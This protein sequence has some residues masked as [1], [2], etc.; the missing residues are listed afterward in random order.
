MENGE[1]KNLQGRSR[2]DRREVDRKKYPDQSSS[3]RFFWR[4]FELQKQLKEQ[5]AS[6]GGANRMLSWVAPPAPDQRLG[7]MGDRPLAIITNRQY[8]R[9]RTGH[10]GQVY[11]AYLHRYPR[12]TLLIVGSGPTWKED[13]EKISPERRGAFRMAIG[14]AAGFLKVNFV[15]TDHYE[16]HDTLKRLQKEFGDDFKNHCT[17]T[18]KP[19]AYPAVDHWWNWRRGEATSV[20]TGIR[21]GL[22]LHFRE[23]ILCGCPMEHAKILHPDQIEKDGP[24]WPPPRFV[25]G[26]FIDSSQKVLTD[27]RRFF[28]I[29]SPPWKGI[30]FSMSGWTKKILGEPRW[31]G[32]M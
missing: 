22:A 4:D 12:Q 3:E 18:N 16:V 9:F 8:I 17:L 19:W 6:S 20:Q 2:L 31:T 11:P 27:A 26:R 7:E 21:I 13:F 25:R 30:V 1:R 14:H 15:V 23:I 5:A 28:E 29:F 10:L 32:T 24:D